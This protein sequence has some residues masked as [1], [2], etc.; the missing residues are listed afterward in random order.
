MEYSTATTGST[1]TYTP[2]SSTTMYAIWQLNAPTAATVSLDYVTRD[3]IYV[4][5]IGYTG[6]ALTGYTLH[7]RV[8]GS[9]S[10]TGTFLGTATTATISNL[11]PNT[12][13]QIY[14]TATNAAGS[15][16]SFGYNCYYNS[17]YA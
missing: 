16:D 1:G 9:G 13:Y 4:K 6:A 15:K 7:Y 3:K 10:Y 2:T 5:D 8:N 14:V 12:T 11:Q 17:R